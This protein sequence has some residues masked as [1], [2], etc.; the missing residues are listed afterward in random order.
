MDSGQS[1]AQR[2]NRHKKKNKTNQETSAD[3]VH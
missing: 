2:K 1:Q 3:A